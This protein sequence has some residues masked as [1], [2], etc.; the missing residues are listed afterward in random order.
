M[1]TYYLAALLGIFL[2]AVCQILLKQGARSSGKGL[3]L[4]Y[5]NKFT[6]VAYL[7]FIIVTLLGLYAYQKLPIKAWVMLAPLTL[8]L[9]A[10]FSFWFLRERLTR[11][12]LVGCLI[13]LI[14]VSIF[15]V[16]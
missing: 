3:L 16:R 12:Q 1:L 9:V 8:V 11:I 7:L 10:L 14:G 13:I 5:F 2:T 6:V 4:L 15:N